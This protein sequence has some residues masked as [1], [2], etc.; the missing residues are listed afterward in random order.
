M[1]HTDRDASKVALVAL[2]ERLKADGDPR[3]LFDVQWSTPHLAG[4]GVVEISRKA[5]LR[6]LSEAIP[7]PA[8]GWE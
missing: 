3:R 6:R 7:A 5:Y 8:P 1:F 2:V 4:L